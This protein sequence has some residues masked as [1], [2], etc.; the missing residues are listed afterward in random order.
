MVP[1]GKEILF[2]QSRHKTV[3]QFNRLQRSFYYYYHPKHFTKLFTEITP[4]YQPRFQ[5]V[6]S[7][8]DILPGYLNHPWHFGTVNFRGQGPKGHLVREAAAPGTPSW[9]MEDGGWRMDPRMEDDDDDDGVED[10][11]DDDDDYYYYY[12][13]DHYHDH[14]Y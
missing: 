6:S 3:F 7:F 5:Q 2:N 10:D 9:M 4:T 1:C 8:F 12:Y 13:Y 14:C 11:D